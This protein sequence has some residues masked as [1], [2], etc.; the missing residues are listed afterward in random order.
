MSVRLEWKQKVFRSEVEGTETPQGV[1][2]SAAQACLQA[3]TEAAGGDLELELVGVKAIKA[4]DAEVVIASVRAV[5]TEDRYRLLGSCAASTEE[6]PA[7]GAV[8]AVLDALNRIM[9]I[10]VAED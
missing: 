9:E 2:R 3:A 6:D 8:L 1:L 5:T 7:R 10:Y 4:F